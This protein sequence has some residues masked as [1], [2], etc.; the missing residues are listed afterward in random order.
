MATPTA[1]THH[2]LAGGV[3]RGIGIEAVQW[4][5]DHR[6]LAFNE[7]RK[8]LPSRHGDMSEERDFWITVSKG[9]DDLLTPC[10]SSI[11]QAKRW[12]R[13]EMERVVAVNHSLE[14]RNGRW[15][16]DAFR[17]EWLFHRYTARRCKRYIAALSDLKEVSGEADQ[18]EYK[19]LSV[20]ELPSQ[21]HELL[22]RL[23]GYIQMG[24]GNYED[25]L[26]ELFRAISDSN[27]D[28][29]QLQR[30]LRQA[31]T[32]RGYQWPPSLASDR[33]KKVEKLVGFVES[34][35]TR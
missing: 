10:K 11:Q 2:P 3:L 26:S 7:T 21:Y 24:D 14:N 25:S 4:L 17:D 20:D 16:T 1:D 19:K 29:H 28:H 9:T 5:E 22:Q 32:R 30:N 34:V 27:E 33:Q 31:V 8:A 6:D 15:A 18:P 13:D 12:H 35:I 23:H